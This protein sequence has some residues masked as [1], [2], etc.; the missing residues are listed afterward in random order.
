MNLSLII[1][2]FFLLGIARNKLIIACYEVRIVKY[3]LAV[4]IK[5]SPE[6][7]NKNVLTIAILSHNFKRT[8]VL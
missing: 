6:K 2:T 5:S 3:I 8:I 4:T 1:Q 7:K